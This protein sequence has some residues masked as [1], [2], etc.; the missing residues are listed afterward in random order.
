MTEI[1]NTNINIERVVCLKVGSSY[2]LGQ[3][4]GLLWSL[5]CF[6]A[7]REHSKRC[8]EHFRAA[9]RI[10]KPA[11]FFYLSSNLTPIL[12]FEKPVLTLLDKTTLAACCSRTIH[13]ANFCRFL[14]FG[15]ELIEPSRGRSLCRTQ[16]KELSCNK[17][18]VSR[19]GRAF[20]SLLVP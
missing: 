1:I 6:K 4:V 14:G 2:S 10:S 5:V 19:I 8:L 13:R 16:I 3:V 11:L 17:L 12:N 20:L 18:Y 7:P 9:R 15:V